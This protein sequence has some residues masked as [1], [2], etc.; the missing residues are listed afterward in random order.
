MFMIYEKVKYLE[1]DECLPI[2]QNAEQWKELATLFED[3]IH[4]LNQPVANIGIDASD[5]IYCLDKGD[6]EG[7]R[8]SL[9]SLRLAVQDL[10]ER[11]GAYKALTQRSRSEETIRVRDIVDDVEKV[12]RRRADKAKVKLDI[13]LSD[14]NQFNRV[15][16]VK[17][18][19]FLF[20]MAIRNLVHNAIEASNDPSIPPDRRHVIIRGI[21]SPS[22]DSQTFPH[23]SV[24]IYVR[25]EGPGIPPK[26]RKRIFER[27]FT[28]KQGGRGLGLGLSLVQSVAESCGGKVGMRD[29]N[30]GAE[31]WLQF[32]AARHRENHERRYDN[33]GGRYRR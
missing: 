15:L 2:S 4:E 9:D 17:G 7:L 29:V 5:A 20:R 21:H 19:P 27:G 16:S 12:L 6:V 10:G 11:I 33:E 13:Q 18:D 31:F 32:P 1:G 23:G 14:D 3:V 30:P 26:I 8:E 28:T 22:E 24:L 25:D